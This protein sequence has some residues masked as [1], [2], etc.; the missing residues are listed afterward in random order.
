MLISR[1]LR[2]G[3]GKA[4]RAA[5]IATPMRLLDSNFYVSGMRVGLNLMSRS[6]TRE[7]KKATARD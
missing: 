7:E 1:R 6:P 4:S 2:L 3:I 5:R